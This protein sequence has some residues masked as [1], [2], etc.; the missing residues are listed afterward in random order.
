MKK[1][2]YAVLAILAFL[3]TSCGGGKIGQIDHPTPV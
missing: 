2:F 1:S 3:I